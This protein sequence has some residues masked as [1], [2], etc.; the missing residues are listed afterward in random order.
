VSCLAL[1]DEAGEFGESQRKRRPNACT[2]GNGTNSG[3]VEKILISRA[4][5]EI[6]RA[7]ARFAT[8]APHW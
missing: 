4:L 6:R 2:T 7:L 1:L 5:E 3:N 8:G